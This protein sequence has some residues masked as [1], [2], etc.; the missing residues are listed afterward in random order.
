MDPRIPEDP[1]WFY[2]LYSGVWEDS[3]LT[4]GVDPKNPEI[5]WATD[6]GNTVRSNDGGRTWVTRAFKTIGKGLVTTRGMDVTTCYGL[7]FDP[8]NPKRLF[9][10]YTDIGAFK[11]EDGG[12]SWGIATTGIPRNWR[13]TTYWIE[14]D[15]KVK[16]R[17]WA[18]FSRNH[19]LPRPK[20]WRNRTG[21]KYEGGV[22]I[23]EDGGN[24]WKVSNSG[25]AAD[26]R[27]PHPAR[28]DEPG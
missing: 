13:N 21:L 19:D 4:M 7:H 11:S 6:Y 23:T 20:M 8:F 16:G 27:N 2:S 17:G 5:C 1:A 26:S 28:S 9:I 10:S 24:S 14:F 12:T 15:P 25:H 18:V 22:G 3:P